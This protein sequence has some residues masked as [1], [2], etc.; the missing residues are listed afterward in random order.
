MK[1]R[2]QGPYSRCAKCAGCGHARYDHRPRVGC[3]GRP[4]VLPV[5]GA[6]AFCACTGFKM[7]KAKV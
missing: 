3:I 1:R 4:A 6:S 2:G 5:A 7:D